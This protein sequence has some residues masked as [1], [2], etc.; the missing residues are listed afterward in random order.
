MQVK[1]LMPPE[2]GLSRETPTGKAV[3]RNVVWHNF[4]CC[5]GI[6]YAS[7][8]FYR[9]CRV[10]KNRECSMAVVANK[11]FPILCFCLGITRTFHPLLYP[12]VSAIVTWIFMGRQGEYYKIVTSD[13]GFGF[14]CPYVHSDGNFHSKVSK[15][16]FIDNISFDK[17]HFD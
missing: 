12:L 4:L 3:G 1:G 13:F 10:S 8:Q 14:G 2:D 17:S 15:L 7:G 5:S 6:C 11:T 16:F 9:N